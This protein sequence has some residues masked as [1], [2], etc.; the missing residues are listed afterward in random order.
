MFFLYIWILFLSL[1]LLLCLSLSLSFDTFK[2]E[3]NITKRTSH[4]L[5]WVKSRTLR[6][7]FFVFIIENYLFMVLL[8]F[9]EHYCCL[10]ISLFAIMYCYFVVG[11]MLCSHP[12]EHI[13]SAIRN[14]IEILYLTSNIILLWTVQLNGCLLLGASMIQL[15]SVVFFFAL[16][17]FQLFEK[18]FWMNQDSVFQIKEKSENGSYHIRNRLMFSIDITKS[19]S[20]TN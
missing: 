9:Y 3:Q 16:F 1:S 15:C 11:G 10:S 20:E 7:I 2:T 14:W 12:K 13:L 19:G 6:F 5:K 18:F 17:F 4:S 8:L